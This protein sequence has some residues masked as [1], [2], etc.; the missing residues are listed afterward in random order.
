L[1]PVEDQY[2]HL[3]SAVDATR[4]H[5]AT[6]GVYLPV[7]GTQEYIGGTDQLFGSNYTVILV[8]I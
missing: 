6:K 8:T 1:A 5:M 4:H 3:T 7:G 2:R